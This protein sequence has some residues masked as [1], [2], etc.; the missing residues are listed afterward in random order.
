MAKQARIEEIQYL[1]GFAFLAVVLQHSIGHYA[2]LPE[3]GLENGAVLAL[4]LIAAKFAVPMFIF[5]T[6]LVLFYN[7]RDKVPFV[8][9]VR[10]RFKDIILPYIIWSTVYAIFFEET[11]TK[12][13]IEC[14]RIL[15]DWFTGKASYHLW[16][17]VMS[18]QLYLLFPVVQRG[19]LWVWNRSKPWM[20]RTG[21]VLLCLFYIYLTAEV[22]N[23]GSFFEGL[24]IPVIT[25]LFTEYADRNALYFFIYF[26][27]GAAVGLNFQLWKQWMMTT[28]WL[29]ISLYLICCVVLFYKIM[30][31]FQTSSGYVIQY[32]YT[33]L[34]QPFMALFLLLSV[35]AMS[36]AAVVLHEGTSTWLCQIFSYLGK[37]SYGAYLAH[38]LMLTVG[39]D[40]TDR[41]LPG[42]N[43]SVRTVAAFVICTLLSVLTAVV[44]SKFNVGRWTVGAP[45][46]RKPV[47]QA[48]S[49]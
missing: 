35:I 22:G 3:T 43:I 11:G 33:L 25:P 31:S 7:Y 40:L 27:M 34:L 15:L 42:G 5:I 14:K 48:K 4:L 19:V 13:W 20:L 47:N 23:I 1:R 8:P 39:T 36:I 49:L 37:H 26:I 28:K 29:W 44:L 9:F 46:P 30:R 18:I 32:N 41:L 10:K 12:I 21:F 2:Y 24:H 17:V 16:Y 6:G 45:A 38:A